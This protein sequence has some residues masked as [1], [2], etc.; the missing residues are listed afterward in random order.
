LRRG[1]LRRVIATVDALGNLRE[2]ADE[3]VLVVVAR[4]PW[5]GALLPASVLRDGQAETLYGESD[6]GVSGGALVIPGVGCPGVGIGR[7]S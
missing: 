1:G 4:S 2:T 5:S 3:R 7:P 6:L